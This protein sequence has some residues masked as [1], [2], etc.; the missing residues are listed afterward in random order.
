MRQLLEAA[1]VTRQIVATIMDIGAMRKPYRGKEAGFGTADLAAREPFAQF[2]A[3]FEEASQHDE[4]HEANAMCLSTATTEGVPSARFVL[5]KKFGPEGFT[6]YTNY[7]SRKAGE[8]DSNPR[9][10]LTFYWAPL[11]RSVR[12]EGG[13][14]RISETES[15][16]Y[17]RSRPLSS[18]IGAAVSQQSQVVAGRAVLAAREAELLARHG[19]EESGE[20]VPRP[21]WGGYRVTPHTVE[22]WQGQ[23]D[24]IHDRIRFRLAGE[25]EM[26]DESVTTRGEASWLIERLEP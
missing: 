22:F 4:I 21:D 12:V 24:R 18:Q 26:I 10:A 6:F 9:A 8:L 11:N 5:L 7:G 1:R 23:S 17:F 20:A 25:G 16:Q 15:E 3:W 14:A 2:T 19:E 13:V